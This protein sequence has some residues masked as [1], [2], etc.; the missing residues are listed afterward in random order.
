MTRLATH[1]KSVA[2]IAA[3]ATVLPAAASAAPTLDGTFPA[4]ANQ[5]ATGPDGAAWFTGGS[6]EFGRIA[7]NGAVTEF[8][9]PGNKVPTAITSGPDTTG[10]P[11]NRIWLAYNGGVIKV[12]PAAPNAGT[13]FPSAKVGNGVRDMAA[14]RNGNLWVIDLD[15]VTRVT[16]AAA[17]TFDEFGA[18][19]SGREIALGGDGRMWWGDSNAF[20]ILAT[21]TAGVTTTQT[22]LTSTYQGI[23]AGPNNQIVFGQPSNLLGR[24]DPGKSLK[25][26][27]DTGGDAGFGIVFGT[28]GAYWAPRFPKDSIGR[29][30]PAGGYTTP[31][32][33][34]A[35]SGPRRIAV[36]ASN[37]LWVTLETSKRIARI[38]GVTPPPAGNGGG[39][40]GTGRDL[41]KP[42]LARL[43]INVAKRRLAVRLSEAAS[44]RLTI[45]RRTFGKRKGKKCR[46]AKKGRTGKR[47]VRYVKVRSLRKAG[48]AGNNT[49][50]MGKKLK[51]ARYRVSLVA[52]DKA[53]NRS[54]TARKG[55]T[56]KKPKRR[57]RR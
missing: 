55:F 52:V 27:T 12:N 40:G 30:T 36:G 50:S 29:L 7:A 56:V 31:I 20:K 14:D 1:L 4:D 21:T 46:A 42:R 43:K 3:L 39:T 37:T 15:G 10:G 13:D 2:A 44:L 23:A 25:L 51:P 57:V 32:K 5:I 26:T 11:A 49:M 22:P 41:V 24:I 18:G 48:K 17:P 53:G 45:E 38:S 28:D 8:V 47:C 16:T 54:A 19:N 34:P 33:L 9:T 35:G 6:K